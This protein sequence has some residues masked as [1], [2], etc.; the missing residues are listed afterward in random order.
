MFVRRFISVVLIIVFVLAFGCGDLLA[1]EKGRIKKIA[2]ATGQVLSGC[3]VYVAGAVAGR[4]FFE[5]VHKGPYNDGS[6]FFNC[7]SCQPISPGPS[8]A[9]FLA[10]QR[11]MLLERQPAIMVNSGLHN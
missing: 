8:L 2:V 5:A 1:A 7:D 9:T 10:Q 6:N 3:V 11:F 4:Y